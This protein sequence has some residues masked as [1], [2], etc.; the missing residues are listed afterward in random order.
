[1]KIFNTMTRRKEEFVP[2]HEGKV[3]IYACGPTVY[4]YFHIGN[5]RMFIV[6]DV[7]RRY[8]EYKGYEV[9]FVQNFTDIDD[10]MIRRANSEGISVK[11]LG[12]RFIEEYYKDAKALGI[13][14]ASV[15][16]RATEH[17][18]EII[19]IVEK[20]IENKLAY[21]VNGD[22]YFDTAAYA[23]YGKLS[24]QNLEDLNAGA[25]ISIDETKKNPADFALW[26]AYK[27]GEPYWESPWGKGRPGWHIEC[28]AMSMRYL[29]ESFD[30]HCG[31]HDLIFPHHENEIAQS[32]GATG[33]PFAKYWMHNGFLNV[34]NQKMAKSKGNFF[35]VRDITK[36]F[37]PEDVRMFMF[38]AH[39]RSPLNF[40]REQIQQAHS[41]L[42]R[43]YSARDKA[44]ELLQSAKGDSMTK[45]ELEFSGELSEFENAFI[46]SMDDDL[47]TAEATAAIFNLVYAINT[48]LNKDSSKKVVESYLS[49][50]EK[51]CSTLGIMNKVDEEL[52][53]E[54]LELLEARRIARESKNWAESDAIRNKVKALGYIIEDGPKGQK[55]KKQ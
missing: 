36:D 3:G 34:D 44:R 42:E 30:I 32:E 53:S 45:E 22:V 5:A 1:M 12:D 41:A 54:V 15:H 51:L 35:T 46:E 40:S 17:I 37:A 13:K 25:R 20:L 52:P 18:K 6:F 33:K 24:G 8:M 29:G 31:G 38:S 7:L 23:H 10:K 39:Y 9:T 11:E 4:D 55:A 43:I 21:T 14:K 2:L 27:E 26:K 48:R 50:L 19:G 28:S 16:P 49:L 47:N